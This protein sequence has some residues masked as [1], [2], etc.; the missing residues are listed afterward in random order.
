MSD[1]VSYLDG[2]SHEVFVSSGINPEDDGPFMVVRR[3]SLNRGTHRVRAIKGPL[4]GGLFRTPEDAQAALD[5]VAQNRKWRVA[6]NGASAAVGVRVGTKLRSMT[7]PVT[8]T[9]KAVG[10]K[11]LVIASDISG[12]QWTI[13]PDM[14]GSRFQVVTW[15]EEH[16]ER[17]DYTDPFA[18]DESDGGAEHGPDSDAGAAEAAPDAEADGRD[19][20]PD[21]AQDQGGEDDA[22]ADRDADRDADPCGAGA[23]GSTGACPDAG[24]GPDAGPDE[25]PEPRAE[26]PGPPAPSPQAPDV[27]QEPAGQPETHTECVDAARDAQRARDRRA[28]RAARPSLSGA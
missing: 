5:A 3:E 7:N 9:V 2:N 18:P 10:E 27:A 8:Y 26:A 13:T 22:D 17:D 14:L 12:R 1:R 4:R 16:V 21:A 28:R 11:D 19:A 15:E 6:S 24:A 25:T 23:G 20:E